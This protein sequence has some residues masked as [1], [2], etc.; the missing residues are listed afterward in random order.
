MHTARDGTSL[1]TRLR[2]VSTTMLRDVDEAYEERGLKFRTRFFPIIYALAQN[3]SQTLSELTIA[4]GFSQPAASK[5]VKQL[6]ADGLVQSSVGDDARVRALRLSAKGRELVASLQ[7]F[8]THVKSTVEALVGETTPNFFD[9]LDA[10]ESGLARRSL[11][12]RLQAKPQA[13]VEVIPFRVQDR[14]AFKTLNLE[15]L[16]AYF[17][18][19]DRDVEIL[20]SPESIL[21]DGGEIYFARRA[22]DIVGTGALVRRGDGEFELAKMAVSEHARGAGIGRMLC[23]KLVERFH[24]RGGR[25]LTLQSNSTLAAALRLYESL[26]FVHYEPSEPAEFERT[27]VHMVLK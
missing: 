16:R 6:V 1:G 18:V 22:L 17:H 27:N 10:L 8:W 7:P 21:D 11:L 24:E 20:G 9:A 2:R 5:T 26:G 15:W 23:A 13:P 4:S 12:E 25:R 3:E 19:E 14:E